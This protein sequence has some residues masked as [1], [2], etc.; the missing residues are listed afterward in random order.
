MQASGRRH[1]DCAD[2]LCQLALVQLLLGSLEASHNSLTKALEIQVTLYKPTQG[3]GQGQGHGT[4]ASSSSN[5]NGNSKGHSGGD[6]GGGE[7]LAGVIHPK[8]VETLCLLSHCLREQGDYSTSKRRLDEA[9]RVLSSVLDQ[10]QHDERQ[11]QG[12]GS[13]SLEPLQHTQYAQMDTHTLSALVKV[14]LGALALDLS[15]YER[16]NDYI[17]S[18]LALRSYV[19]GDGHPLTLQSLHLLCDINQRRGKVA[20][21]KVMLLRC[22][23]KLEAASPS[24]KQHPEVAGCLI[25]LGEIH[26]ALAEYEPAKEV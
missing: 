14:G 12:L 16:A 7:S 23:A 8:V 3:P 9:H 22:I 1:L 10:Q 26:L 15:E 18:S 19:L 4:T 5:G 21:A 11:G 6:G 24:A 25:T 2:S 17:E 20:S 13:A